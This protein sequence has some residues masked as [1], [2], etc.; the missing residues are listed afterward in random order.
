MSEITRFKENSRKPRIN[1]IIIVEGKTDTV[2]LKGIFDCETIETNGSEISNEKINLIKE[3]SLT[4]GVILFLDPDYQGKKIR[5]RLIK[6]LK[7]YKEAFID[8]N[9]LKDSKKKGIA[10]A[11]N[12]SIL[13]AFNNLI[14][15]DLDNTK[16]ISWIEYLSLNLDTKIKRIKLCK[17]LGIPYGNNKSLFRYLSLLKKDLSEIKELIS[18]I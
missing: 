6:E 12:E 11:S 5:S 8:I 18:D 16:T 1:E 7:K 2:K 4:K 9:E 15:S 17:K 14:S 3:L 13:K 10:E